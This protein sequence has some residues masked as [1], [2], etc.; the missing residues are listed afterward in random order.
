MKRF[1]QLTALMGVAFFA[2]ACAG[3]GGA[4]RPDA[5]FR[6]IAGYKAPVIPPLGLIYSRVKAPLSARPTAVGPKTGQATSHHI[7]LP[8]L[9]FPGLWTGIDL[10]SW[11]DASENTALADGGITEASQVD[12]EF[13]SYFWVYKTFTLEVTGQ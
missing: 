5:P 6:M 11:G 4:A 1:L 7:S 9:P 12:Y 2:A 10:F 8:P 3:P 13:E